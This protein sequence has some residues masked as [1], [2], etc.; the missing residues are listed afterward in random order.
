[1]IHTQVMAFVLLCSSLIWAEVLGGHLGWVERAGAGSTSQNLG[2][3][4]L[5]YDRS[6][7]PAFHNPAL[8]AIQ[9]KLQVSLGAENRSLGRRGGYLAV[10]APWKN[11]LGFGYAMLYRGDA[12][13]R[14]IDSND[15]NLGTSTP[16]FIRHSAA[17]AW[18]Q[19]KNQALGVSFDWNS[20]H[21]DIEGF[22]SHSS[23][24]RLT[25]S[26]YKAWSGASMGVAVRNIGINAKLSSED[27][28]QF[29]ESGSV[30]SALDF[31]PKTIDFEFR[32][33][34]SRV[35]WYVKN[36]SYLLR[37]V[38]WDWEY[39]AWQHRLGAGLEVPLSRDFIAQFGYRGEYFS[40]DGGIPGNLSGGISW[41]IPVSQDRWAEWTIGAIMERQAQFTPI[42]MS[43]RFFW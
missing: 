27:E 10:N 16:G 35:I 21:P 12:G 40:R 6:A 36:S 13:I 26:Y 43:L 34:M 2:G 15:E 17:L 4:G 5:S 3:T 38:I 14:V 37:N 11:R 20:Y 22:Q 33:P 42:H 8:V 41:R 30:A 7:V 28:I 29:D 1:M 9:R 32:I 25:A 24:I 23:P 19:S 31:Y 39:E 18:R